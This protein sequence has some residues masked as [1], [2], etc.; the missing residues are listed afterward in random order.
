MNHQSTCLKMCDSYMWSEY[1]VRV[2][3]I[4]IHIVLKG[5]F[6]HNVDYMFQINS[7]LK[8]YVF[9]IKHWEKIIFE[10]YIPHNL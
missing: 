7:T 6:D 9:N 10:N 1:I 4:H 3:L 2:W 5:D 8:T